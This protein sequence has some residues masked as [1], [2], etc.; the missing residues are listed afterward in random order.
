MGMTN[1]NLN[2]LESCTVVK[3]CNTPTL[4]MG[5]RNAVGTLIWSDALECEC[6]TFPLAN[7][8]V[9]IPLKSF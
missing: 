1:V 6:V 8:Q 4:L 9:K 5:M 7:K 3:V 2:Q